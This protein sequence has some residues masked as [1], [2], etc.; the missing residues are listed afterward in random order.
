MECVAREPGSEEYMN[1]EKYEIRTW[2]IDRPD[3]LREL[4]GA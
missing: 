1:S 4:I 3:S 2:D